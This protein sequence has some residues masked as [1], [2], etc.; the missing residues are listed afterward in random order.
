MLTVPSAAMVTCTLGLNL[1][2]AAGAR[3]RLGH[4]RA[5]CRMPPATPAPPIVMRKLRRDRAVALCRD[6]SFIAQAF[7]RRRA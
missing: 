1:P 4:R 6:V 5:D 7:Q 3:R 2:A